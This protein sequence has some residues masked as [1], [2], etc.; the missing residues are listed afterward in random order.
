M[1][2]RSLSSAVAL[3]QAGSAFLGRKPLAVP[4]APD[5]VPTERGA[6]GRT[7]EGLCTRGGLRGH[8]RTSNREENSRR[9]A[10][11]KYSHRKPPCRTQADSSAYSN[12]GSCCLTERRVDPLPIVVALHVGEQI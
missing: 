7:G 3:L 5:A 2:P 11:Q 12:S 6:L 8:T 4:L 1:W 9:C 10:Q